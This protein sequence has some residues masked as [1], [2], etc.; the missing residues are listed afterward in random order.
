MSHGPKNYVRALALMLLFL[1]AGSASAN[2]FISGDYERFHDLL[3]TTNSLGDDIAALLDKS[4]PAALQD[5]LIRLNGHLDAFHAELRGVATLVG[6]SSKM[7]DPNDERIVFLFL[8]NQAK[9]FLKTLQFKRRLATLT[10][11]KCSQDGTVTAKVQAALRI[12]DNAASLVESIIKK[13]IPS[14]PR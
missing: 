1:P 14:L 5:C 2:L 4:P 6:V 3:T 8:D 11:D 9:G 7:V 13:I 10:E 12:Y